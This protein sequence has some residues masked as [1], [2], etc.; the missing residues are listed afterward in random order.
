MTVEFAKDELIREYGKKRTKFLKA[1]AM[2][3]VALAKL[4]QPP[5]IDTGASIN[6][7]THSP[8]VGDSVKV[9]AP[10]FYDVYLEGRYG[11]MAKT[12]DELPAYME[13]IEEQYFG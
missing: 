5:H 10:L 13:K 6:A 8:V 1:S 12:L 11:I 2:M 4:N 3:G 9:S 7:K